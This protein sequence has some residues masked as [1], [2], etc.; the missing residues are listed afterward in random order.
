[1]PRY[2]LINGKIVQFTAEEEASFD[3]H[4]NYENSNEAKL[5]QIKIITKIKRN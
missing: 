4:E 1:M 2:N 3:I 5:D